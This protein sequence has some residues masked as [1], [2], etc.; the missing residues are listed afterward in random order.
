MNRI[1]TE[2]KTKALES[3]SPIECLRWYVQKIKGKYSDKFKSIENH[4][5]G[6]DKSGFR[7][8]FRRKWMVARRIMEQYASQQ[9]EANFK[10][11]YAIVQ[12]KD[13]YGK[14]LPK[15][16]VN[17]GKTISE[18]I[19]DHFNRYISEARGSSYKQLKRTN[20]AR[21]INELKRFD[22]YASLFGNSIEDSFY[23]VPWDISSTNL[24]LTALEEFWTIYYFIYQ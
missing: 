7:N 18:S 6:L 3:L 23:I 16:L 19:F 9:E 5:E 20:R 22:K 1:V 10:V 11:V 14:N 4:I 2:E 24:E 13:I 8:P 17:I 12:I 15:S 21:F